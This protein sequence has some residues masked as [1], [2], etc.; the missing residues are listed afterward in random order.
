MHKYYTQLTVL[1]RYRDIQGE[2]S[3]I[4]EEED[5]ALKFNMTGGPL[6]IEEAPEHQTFTEFLCSWGGTWILK[7]LVMPEDPNWIT[8]GH[9]NNTMVC[10]MDG[11]YKQKTI[12]DICTA[13]WAIHCT[14]TNHNIST[15]LVEKSDSASSY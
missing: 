9:Q 8:E 12:L 11:S 14:A 4:V 5:G 13:G 3:S 6:H 2:P 10:V 15:T 1:H 7:G